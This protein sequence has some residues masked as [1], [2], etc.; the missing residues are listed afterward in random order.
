MIA[1]LLMAKGTSAIGKAKTLSLINA[2][3]RGSAMQQRM[4]LDSSYRI[5]K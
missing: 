1:K 4:F 3:D 2:D 5:W